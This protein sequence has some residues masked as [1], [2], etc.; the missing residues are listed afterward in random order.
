M[1][2]LVFKED[3]GLFHHAQDARRC[4]DGQVFLSQHKFCGAFPANGRRAK[5][6][7]NFEKSFEGLPASCRGTTEWKG[8]LP[9]CIH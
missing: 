1:R 6:G 7:E 8:T 2:D 5:T 9:Q 3:C 4:V